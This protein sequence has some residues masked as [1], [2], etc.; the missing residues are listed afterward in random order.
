MRR[1]SFGARTYNPS[2]GRFDGVDPLAEK[3]SHLSSYAYVGNNPVNAIDPNGRLIILVNGHWNKIANWLGMSPGEAGKGYW[4]YFDR[5]F[6]GSVTSFFKDQKTDFV[7]G[8]SRMGFDQ[9]GSYRFRSGQKWAKKNYESVMAGLADGETIK[10]VGH[11]EGSAYAAGIADY[12]IKRAKKDGRGSVIEFMLQLSPDEADE[13]D[14]PK[15]PTTYRIH[16]VLDPVSPAFY[17]LSGVDYEMITAGY[18]K[19]GYNE[20]FQS[21]GR[22]VTRWA[23]NQLQ[24]ALNQFMQDPNV[25]MTTNADGSTTYKRTDQ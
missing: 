4:N 21:H 12:F 20:M 16:D 15:E 10:L 8:S 14:N 24:G 3:Y 5:G 13:F 23:I 6:I 17:Y 1:I 19:I 25:Q 9:S 11:S 2:I 7:D 18:K 22:T